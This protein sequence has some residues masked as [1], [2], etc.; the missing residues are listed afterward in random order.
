MGVAFG[1][2]FGALH[3]HPLLWNPSYATALSLVRLLNL[4]V[5]RTKF[6]CRLLSGI[7]QV[8]EVDI[9]II[10]SNASIAFCKFKRSI[11]FPKRVSYNAVPFGGVANKPRAL[12]VTSSQ[13]IS[14]FSLTI[15]VSVPVKV[16]VALN[17]LGKLVQWNLSDLEGLGALVAS[18]LY[19]DATA[20]ALNL[21]NHVNVMD[22]LFN[23]YSEV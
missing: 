13:N 5:T 23:L 20:Q 4:V 19:S 21:L 3:A 15:T 10:R 6:F 2:N 16:C 18:L 12:S 9:C 7:I 17:K 8:M 14:I 22:S 11:P 1:K